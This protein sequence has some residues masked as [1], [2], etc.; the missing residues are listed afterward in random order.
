MPGEY[1]G[2]LVGWTHIEFNG[3]IILKVQSTSE[4]QINLPIQI[5]EHYFMMTNNQS[6][7]LANFLFNIS[8]QSPP[9][10]RNKGIISR[11]IGKFL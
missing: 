11:L 1:Y 4:S 2:V 9:L 3:H 8:E 10:R 5:D 7:V 6:L